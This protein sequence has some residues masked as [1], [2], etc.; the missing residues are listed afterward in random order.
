MVIG[1]LVNSINGL[2]R[3]RVYVPSVI[4]DWFGN[5]KNRFGVLGRGKKR[6]FFNLVILENDDVFNY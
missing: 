6:V 2:E 5:R 4:F 1:I 3:K